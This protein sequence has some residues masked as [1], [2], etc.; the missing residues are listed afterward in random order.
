[1]GFMYLAIGQAPIILGDISKNLEIMEKM[2]IEAQDKSNSN[3]DLIVFPELFITGYNLR[4]NYNEVAEK[5]PSSGMAQKGII[6]LAEKFNTH[7]ITGIVERSGKS[8]FNSAIIVGPEGYIGHYQKR[9]LPNFGPFEE[10][11]YFGE[12][13]QSNVFETPFGK[14]GVQICYDIF[15]PETSIELAQ[16]GADLII[17]LSASPTTSRP[18]FHRMLPARAIESTC[19]YAYSNNIGTQGSLT[20]AGESLVVDP[21]GKTIAEIPSFEE[22]VIVCELMFE[23]LERFRDARPVLRDSKKRG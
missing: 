10:K 7:I 14:I 21:R 23:D 13:N 9:F 22:G 12:G 2:I 20:F 1:M 19:F 5:I 15:F 16:K 3:L 11:M 6:E 8:L 4:D 17:N 18:L